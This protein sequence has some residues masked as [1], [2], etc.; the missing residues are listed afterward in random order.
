MR[1][2]GVGE[3]GNILKFEV[4]ITGGACGH[5]CSC[6]FT[7]NWKQS[8][9]DWSTCDGRTF[10]SPEESRKPKEH[11]SEMLLLEPGQGC[12]CRY[13]M[14]RR[15]VAHARTASIYGGLLRIYRI[16]SADSRQRVALQV[17]GVGQGADS[18][19][20]LKPYHITNHFTKPR[21]VSWVRHNRWRTLV[22]AV[23]NLRVS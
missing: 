1:N 4:N 17:V 16:N 18:L 20:T 3:L 5:Q 9:K 10:C 2:A 14:A 6:V 19:R 23:T 12:Y 22:N 13:S 15:Q 7:L 8:Y 11:F 21:P